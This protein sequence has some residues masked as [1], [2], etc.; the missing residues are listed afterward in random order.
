LPSKDFKGDIFFCATGTGIAPFYG[1][2]YE[3]LE[4]KLINYAG[5]IYLL[6]GAAYSDELVLTDEF[7]KLQENHSN[8]HFITAISREDKNSIDGG[9]MYIHHRL[10]EIVDKVKS[11]MENGGIVYICGGPKGMEKGVISS[12]HKI[13]QSS[14]S[15]EEFE[16]EL[17][18]KKQLFV[19][20]Y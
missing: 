4:H 16:K 7:L 14:T 5:N 11:G 13:M 10:L 8:F 15:E 9:R 2:T 3:L 1:M 6:Y 20:T 17:E 12:L 18:S 19:E